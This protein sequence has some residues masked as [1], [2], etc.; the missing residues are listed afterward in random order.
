MKGK[1][2]KLYFK[3]LLVSKAPKLA[4]DAGNDAELGALEIV[5]IN[6]IYELAADDF[7]GN[8][9]HAGAKRS[10]MDRKKVE[11]HLEEGGKKQSRK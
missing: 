1:L 10:F 4:V 2:K 6:V 3:G 7:L 5:I 9:I 8:C 11:G